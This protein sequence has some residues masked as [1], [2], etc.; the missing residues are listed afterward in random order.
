VEFAQ[1]YEASCDRCL[2][3][4][5]VVVRDRLLAEDLV[6]EGFARALARWS[7]LDEHPDPT[8][9]VVRTALN[10]N[11]S[12]WRRRRREVAM[13][14]LIDTAGQLDAIDD[15]DLATALAGLPLRQR[16]VIALRVYLDL[17]LATCAHVLGIS[18]GAVGTHYRRAMAALKTQ[19]VPTSELEVLP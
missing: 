10:L 8:A 14:D 3:V 13:P 7:K 19:L 1:F 5:A 4:V 11:V 12:R 6:A 15:Q 17:D 16:Q 18:A 9:W 2:N